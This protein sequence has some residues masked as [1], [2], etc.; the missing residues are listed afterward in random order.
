MSNK[1][2]LDEFIKYTNQVFPSIDSSIKESVR[3]ALN[4]FEINKFN[5]FSSNFIGGICQ[6]DIL[7]K[8]PFTIQ[9][10]NGNNEALFTK[11][12]VI[13]NSCDI[14]NDNKILLAPLISYADTDEF[15]K[16][17]QLDLLN[18]KY[19]GKM[20]LTNSKIE[21][22]YVDFSKIQSFSKKVIFKLIDQKKVKLEYSLSQVGWYFLLTKLTIHFMRKEDHETF[23]TRTFGV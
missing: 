18:N 4:Q 2:F 10:D 21:G 16:D 23:L 5:W 19:N 15:N 20:C 11:A 1:D 9:D 7:D 17:Q 12:M 6:G 22:Y 3:E 14:E 13:S 8:I